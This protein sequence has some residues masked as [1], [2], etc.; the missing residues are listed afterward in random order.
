MVVPHQ[1]HRQLETLR[2]RPQVGKG[3]DSAALLDD[4]NWESRDVLW[5]EKTERE[6]F[7]AACAP[8]EP[9]IGHCAQ[10]VHHPCTLL[11]RHDPER[12]L[13]SLETMERLAILPRH[14]RLP[15]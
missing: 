13:L 14:D 15:A 7:L 10:L 8:L 9:V 11:G 12:C 5:L 3:H 6:P 1:I 2:T 4:G